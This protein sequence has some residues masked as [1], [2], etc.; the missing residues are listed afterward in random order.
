[1][2]GELAPQGAGSPRSARSSWLRELM[3]SL[4]LHLLQVVLDGVATGEQA[5]A[6]L[7]ARR[8]VRGQPRDLF[9]LGSQFCTGVPAGALRPSPE[10]LPLGAAFPG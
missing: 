5:R 6:D 4:A 8:A 1:M 3:A 7:G 10:Q 2:G 9:L